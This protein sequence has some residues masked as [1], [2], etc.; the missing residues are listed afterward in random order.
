MVA[1]RL[2][3][4]LSYSGYGVRATRSNP[5]VLTDTETAVALVGSG[6]FEYLEP[7][8]EPTPPEETK[9]VRKRTKIIKEVDM[10][11]TSERI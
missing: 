8:A 6:H 10:D 2:K 11:G 5:V 4:H 3:K 7:P 1:V 9:P